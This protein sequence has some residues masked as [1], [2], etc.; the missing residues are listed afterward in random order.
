MLRYLLLL[1]GCLSLSVAAQDNIM[2]CHKDQTMSVPPTAVAGHL[3]HGD[4]L[5]ACDQ[6]YQYHYYPSVQVYFDPVR[7][8][9][10]Y[11]DGEIWRE[12]QALPKALSKNLGEFILIRHAMAYPLEFHHEIVL[13][14]PFLA[15]GGALA[16]TV[17]Q[18]F[19]SVAVYF[20]QAKGLYHYVSEGEWRSAVTLPP[21]LQLNRKEM[22]QIEYA[23]SAPYE[24]H[25]ETVRKFGGSSVTL[26]HKDKKTMH[27]PE[28][29]VQGHLGH[30]DYLGACD[31]RRYD[32]KSHD[33]KVKDKD[34][35]KDKRKDDKHKQDKHKEEKR[36]DKHDK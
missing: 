23:T 24:Y 32:K 19:P 1:S 17:F 13:Q 5:G 10:F 29:A 20:D 22:I 34:K 35:D 21:A 36:K 8:L 3:Q 18:Y 26:C 16:L 2:I 27:L 15:I 11:R 25:Q 28:S 12:D 4:S 9:Y 7:T 14:T 31:T 6:A 30:G 33:G